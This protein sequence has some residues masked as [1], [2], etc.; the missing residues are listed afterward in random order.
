MVFELLSDLNIYMSPQRH[1][2]QPETTRINFSFF[3]TGQSFE[4]DFLAIGTF[5]RIL[6]TSVVMPFVATT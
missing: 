3:H 2:Y 4:I 5:C 1:K 6:A